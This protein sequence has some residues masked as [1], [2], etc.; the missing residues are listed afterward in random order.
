MSVV[1]YS[2]AKT[3]LLTEISKSRINAHRYDY[4]C[5]LR[6]AQKILMSNFEIFIEQF[7]KYRQSVADDSITS[8]LDDD[9]IKMSEMCLAAM[10]TMEETIVKY[11]PS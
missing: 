1:K 4:R 3:D 11:I 2:T 7:T 6:N 9:F 8:D 5:N 10:I